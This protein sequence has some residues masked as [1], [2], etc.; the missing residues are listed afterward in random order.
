MG[1]LLL[2]CAR[3]DSVARK[4]CVA[5]IRQTDRTDCVVALCD[6]V[7]RVQLR[8]GGAR[9]DRADS[10]DDGAVGGRRSS[11][12]T[13]PLRRQRASRRASERTN[14]R[15][16]SMC[17]AADGRLFADA[18]ADDDDST[19]LDRILSTRAKRSARRSLACS[20]ASKHTHAHKRTRRRCRFT[21]QCAATPPMRQE[22]L[23]RWAT[24]NVGASKV[25]AAASE[26]VAC[27]TGGQCC[28]RAGKS[29]APL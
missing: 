18:A 1:R 14:G 19:R 24:T 28:G 3:L 26:F 16:C 7:W 8:T 6:C 15:A 5:S 4:S 9:I 20:L 22:R 13:A 10:D 21:S 11:L 2:S 29:V 17:N 27:S 25:A 12:H 23:D